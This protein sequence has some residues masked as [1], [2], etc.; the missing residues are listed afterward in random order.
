MT[1][2]TKFS[3]GAVDVS[4]GDSSAHLANA[5]NPEDL[6]RTGAFVFISLPIT[7]DAPVQINIGGTK[8]ALTQ[9]FPTSFV[10]ILDSVTVASGIYQE[11]NPFPSVHVLYPLQQQN[12]YGITTLH[13][14]AQ[15]DPGPNVSATVTWSVFDGNGKERPGQS[16]DI[17]ISDFSDVVY[18]KATATNKYGSTESDPVQ[19][20]IDPMSVPPGNE[21]Y[22]RESGTLTIT[23]NGVD[24]PFFDPAQGMVLTMNGVPLLN[25]SAQ[26]AQIHVGQWS[27]LHFQLWQ[28]GWQHALGFNYQIVESY[29]HINFDETDYYTAYSFNFTLSIDSTEQAL[30]PDWLYA[31]PTGIEDPFL[32]CPTVFTSPINGELLLQVS[33]V[34]TDAVDTLFLLSPVKKFLLF[35]PSGYLNDT[36]DCG[37]VNA[38]D[39]VQ[40]YLHSDMSIDKDQNM[41]PEIILP[42]TGVMASRAARSG[43]AGSIFPLKRVKPSPKMTAG[44]K[45]PQK[46]S[47][48]EKTGSPTNAKQISMPQFAGIQQK[49][50]RIKASQHGSSNQ[51]NAAQD[52]VD[53]QTLLLFEDWANLLYN[54][55]VAV[56]WVEQTHS[57][58][59]G[60]TKYY[61]AV[62]DPDHADKLII[63]ESFTPKNGNANVTFDPPELMKG[64]KLG[65]YWEYK[66][67]DGNDLTKSQPGSIRLIGRYWTPD[68]SYKVKLTAHLLSE[69][70]DGDYVIEVKKP[71]RLFDK[72][73]VKGDKNFNGD[74]EYNSTLDIRNAT[75]NI[76]SLCIWYANALGMPPQFIKSQ[77]FQES[78]KTGYHFHPSYRYEPFTDDTYSD[79]DQS[80]FTDAYL[81][82]PF[83]VTENSMGEGDPIPTNHKHVYPSNYPTTPTKIGEFTAKHWNRYWNSKD[84]KVVGP[85]YLT[86]LWREFNELAG[87]FLDNPGDFATDEVKEYVKQNYT[88]VGQTRKGA[89][90]G[91]LQMVYTTAQE[92]GYNKGKTIATSIAPEKL[93]DQI[94]EMPF[95]ESF[96]ETKIS[97]TFHSAPFSKISAGQWPNGWEA[98]WKSVFDLYDPGKTDYAPSVMANSQKFYPQSK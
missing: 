4:V 54:K 74:T 9:D 13:G 46:K 56:T 25:A 18:V 92:K 50:T 82:Q 38:G 64:D 40:F 89:S 52:G 17:D 37:P 2:D 71:A 60:E 65:V 84:L 78:D 32:P 73:A 62:K 12:I 98:T 21:I 8:C 49:G 76:D 3:R 81:T 29:G 44:G 67:A 24:A 41:Y 97:K 88:K 77:I 61:Y 53:P 34:S 68:Q 86:T 39:T 91:I 90:Y 26:T 30:P 70:R 93:N 28:K 66:D 72:K 7:M 51:L 42:D 79:P 20:W 43:P 48:I 94:V 19:I 31:G 23:I 36:V 80:A 5:L 15:V 69:K 14:E 83:V 27:T 16:S 22:P 57:I 1:R 10:V 55:I 11:T 96:M 58:L 87:F 47:F 85:P 63:K 45:L 75:L 59:L 35:Q 6:G 95:Y 33:S